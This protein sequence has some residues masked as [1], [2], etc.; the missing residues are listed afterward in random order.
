LQTDDVASTNRYQ[1][2][3]HQRQLLEPQ[4]GRPEE[5]LT[6]QRVMVQQLRSGRRRRQL[7]MM[8]M[9]M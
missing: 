1:L 5:R 2:V 6:D 3:R 4:L 9:M 7:M 8:M